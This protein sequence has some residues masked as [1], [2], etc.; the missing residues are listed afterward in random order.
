LELNR[1]DFAGSRVWTGIM[2][3]PLRGLMPRQDVSIALLAFGLSDTSSGVAAR[4]AR[5]SWPLYGTQKVAKTKLA[6]P[7]HSA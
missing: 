2:M 4:S 1:V 6:A 7:Y 3:K 5:H